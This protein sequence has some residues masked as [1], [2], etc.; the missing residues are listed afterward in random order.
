MQVKR[1]KVKVTNKDIQGY[2][3]TLFKK[4]NTIIREKEGNKRGPLH[5][6]NIQDLYT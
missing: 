2:V 4:K 3:A 5:E 6:K 1:Y